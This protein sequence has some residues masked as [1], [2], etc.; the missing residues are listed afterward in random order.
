[1]IKTFRPIDGA[2]L[3]K[4]HIGQNEKRKETDGQF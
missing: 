2:L 3:E 1:M 4:E